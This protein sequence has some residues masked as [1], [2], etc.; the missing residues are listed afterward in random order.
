MTTNSL[1][2]TYGA[3]AATLVRGAGCWLWD[4]NG[5]KY[6]DG[7]SGIA[8]CGLGHSH[9]D[10]TA[11]VAEQA[12]VL[13]HCSNF[14]DIPKQLELAEKLCAISGM[15]KVFF[16][17]SGAEANEAAIKIARLYGHRRGIK[18]PTVLVM[19]NAFHGRT[20]ATLS[21]SGGRRVQAGFEPLVAG[22]V[23]APYNDID[24]INRIADNNANICAVL[25]EPIQG[26]GGVN[27]PA[28]N[29]LEDLKA[30]CERR[31]W[32]L[33]ADE[34][35]TG[36]GRTGKY[37]CYQHSSV[38]PDVV[39]TSKGLGNGVPIGACLATGLAADVMQPG[40]HGSTFG[41][42]PL[43]CAAALAVITCIEQQQLSVRAA[44]VGERIMLGLQC[45]LTSA[46]NVVAIRGR[47]CMI[48]IQLDRP[49]KS[50]FLQALRNGLVINVTADSVIRLLPA[51]IMSD[52][53]ADLLI[54]TLAPLI[55]AF[56]QD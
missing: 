20:L 40:N 22:F 18:L 9:P 30:L 56:K 15:S 1:M 53:E 14:F 27:L 11:A 35:Q 13:T 33:M 25:V 41:G 3:R 12:G 21:A 36:N 29:Y 26:E 16:G 49:C 19:D 52:D 51:L 8:V 6:L 32:L 23:R 45:A 17:N 38:L 55:G 42:N 7:L 28:D 39:T 4:D 5:K 31:K 37:F 46:D 43:S 48:G 34:V 50:L 24:A 10:V 54:D 2:N 44:A 47:G